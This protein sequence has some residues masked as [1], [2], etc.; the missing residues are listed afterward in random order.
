MSVSMIVSCV[1]EVRCSGRGGSVDAGPGQLDKC[2][3]RSPTHAP[4]MG[5]LLTVATQVQVE[6]ICNTDV[7]DAEE[8]LVP[9]LELALVEDLDGD[10]GRVLD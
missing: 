4:K 1:G 10:D 3:P 9:F 7:D 5:G 2:P 8:A 6:D